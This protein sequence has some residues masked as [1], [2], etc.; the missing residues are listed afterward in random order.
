MSTNVFVRDLDLAVHNSLDSR[1]LEVVADGLT[2]LRGVQLAIDTTM[3]SPF[4]RDGTT[5]PRA[6]NFD[7]A[8]LLDEGRKLPTVNFPVKV[9]KRA[10]LSWQRSGREVER[11]DGTI[12]HCSGESTSPVP[13]VLQGR[14]ETA[15]VRRWSA[16]VLLPC[17]SWTGALSLARLSPQSVWS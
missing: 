3:E 17:R 12:P 6:A 9:G 16:T 1:R 13:L 7:G 10:S 14:A 4:R 11:G 2:L 15:W 5:R 8:A